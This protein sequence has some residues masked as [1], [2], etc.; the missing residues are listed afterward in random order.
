M[1][2]LSSGGYARY[3][4]VTIDY[5]SDSGSGLKDTQTYRNNDVSYTYVGPFDV[6][7]ARAYVIKATG[8]D[9][10]GNFSSTTTVDIDVD[11][12]DVTE[13][14]VSNFTLDIDVRRN[15]M[16]YATVYSSDGQSGVKQVYL[17]DGA[18][19]SATGAT[20]MYR[21]EIDLVNNNSSALVSED[22]VGNKNR[23]F[24][25]VTFADN[26]DYYK[27]LIERYATKYHTIDKTLYTD[28]AAENIETAYARLNTVILGLIVGGDF[29]KADFDGA[30][31]GIDDAIEAK[32]VTYVVDAP[33][34]Y[35][36]GMLTYEINVNDFDGYKKGEEIK[37]VF[38][39][40][41]VD[42]SFV[43]KTDYKEGFCDSFTLTLYRN[44]TE[45]TSELNSGIKVSLA[46]PAGY[47]ERE[48]TL[49]FGDEKV[50]TK[51]ITNY[52][53]FTLKK[54]GKYNLVISGCAEKKGEKTQKHITV[55]GHK[56]T[57]PVFFGTVFGVAGGAV[58]IVVIIIAVSIRAK[59]RGY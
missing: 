33:S 48:Y 14:V 31:A 19:F 46:K 9:N 5:H 15:D 4:T 12:F 22:K 55:F 30:I 39:T 8:E 52:I 20:G 42:N 40:A 53:E 57:Y 56:L 2:P 44:G 49:F 11:S 51:S 59:R 6:S 29:A 25:L 37:L 7:V 27:Q 3:Y 23:S 16:C 26:A 47:Y 34:S 58:I 10:V 24:V 45:V 1:S 54:G 32:N 38:K 41:D 17:E 13:P 43:N 18:I 21:A 35:L 50:E 28:K 36:T